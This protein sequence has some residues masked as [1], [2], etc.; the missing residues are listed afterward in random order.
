MM[1]VIAILIRQIWVVR[2]AV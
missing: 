2:Q 1:L